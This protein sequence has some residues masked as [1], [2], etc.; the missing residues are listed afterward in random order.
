V[1][2]H[3]TLARS[4]SKRHSIADAAALFAVSIAIAIADAVAPG[5]DGFALVQRGD[6]TLWIS[7]DATEDWKPTASGGLGGRGSSPITRSR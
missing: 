2:D 4:E 7:E 6:I 3:G 5:M 1:A